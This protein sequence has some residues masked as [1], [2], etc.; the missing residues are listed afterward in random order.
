MKARQVVL[1]FFT[2]RHMRYNN[3][4]NDNNNNNVRDRTCMPGGNVSSD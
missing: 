4:N 1:P 3:N 2:H